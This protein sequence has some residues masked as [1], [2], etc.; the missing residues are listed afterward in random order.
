MGRGMRRQ[1]WPVPGAGVA[2]VEQRGARQLV[3]GSGRPAPAG[4]RGQPAPAVCAQG[5][6]CRVWFG[7]CLAQSWYAPRAP[8]RGPDTVI[9]DI[10]AD[11]AHVS[12]RTARRSRPGVG[13][14]PPAAWPWLGSC[15]WPPRWRW[16]PPWKPAWRSCGT[17]C[18][19]PPA[20]AAWARSQSKAPSRRPRSRCPLPITWTGWTSSNVLTRERRCG[21]RPGRSPRMRAMS[22]QSSR[23]AACEGVHGF[24][25]SGK[26]SAGGLVRSGAEAARHCSPM[27]S[28][29]GE[30]AAENVS[31]R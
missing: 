21:S 24:Y 3:R 5:K 22:L 11:D 16:A 7:Q 29:V 14:P 13:G 20:P 19:T 23:L 25:Q 8:G 12:T 18:W 9:A 17:R 10:N 1:V 27:W 6:A 28:S 15:R 4:G 2:R 31:R 26:W 30:L